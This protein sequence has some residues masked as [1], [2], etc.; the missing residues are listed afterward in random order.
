MVHLGDPLE[1]L[2]WAY[3][4]LWSPQSSLPLD[5]AVAAYAAAAGRDVPAADLLY[6][7]IF[8]EMKFAVIS[9]TAARSYFD[10]KT[11]NLR[12]AGRMFA[13]RECLQ[14]CLDWVDLREA[15]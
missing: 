8:S 10:G 11:G 4:R 9:L 15:A 2:A 7:R 14:R 5:D 3:R 6:Y 1:D 12:L 13:V